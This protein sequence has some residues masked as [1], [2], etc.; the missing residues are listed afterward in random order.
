MGKVDLDGLVTHHRLAALRTILGL[1]CQTEQ[2][3][4]AQMEMVSKKEKTPQEV[5]F[6]VVK[7]D[8]ST[9]RLRITDEKLEKTRKKLEL[10]V[11]EHWTK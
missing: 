4:R 7:I 3:V 10:W 2:G 5:G 11:K 6:E 8:D 1:Q 9:S